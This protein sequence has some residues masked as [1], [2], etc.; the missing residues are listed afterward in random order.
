MARFRLAMAVLAAV[1]PPPDRAAPAPAAAPKAPAAGDRTEIKIESTIE[2]KIES[3]SLQEPDVK[4]SRQLSYVRTMECSQVV[5]SVAE[6]GA[7]TLRVTVGTAK[8]Q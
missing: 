1:A 3:S 8:L 7:P 2:L 6:G 4:Q 5:Q